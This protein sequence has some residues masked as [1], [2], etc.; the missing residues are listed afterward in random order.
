MP[1]GTAIVLSSGGPNGLGVARALA[2]D[3]VAVA[4][5]AKSRDDPAL[6]SNSISWSAVATEFGQLRDSLSALPAGLPQPRVLIPTSD[7]WVSTVDS[8]RQELGQS[9]ALAISDAHV[10]STLI[11]KALETRALQNAGFALPVTIH[12]LSIGADQI[13]SALGLPLIVK[14]RHSG[15]VRVLRA[16]NVIVHSREALATL[17]D[18][19][20]SSIDGLIAQEVIPG[21]DRHQFV[22]NCCFDRNSRLVSAFTFRRIRLSPAHRGVTSFAVSEPNLEIIS[23]VEQF[24]GIFGYVGPAMLEFKLDPR[25]GAFKYLETN[26]RVGMCNWFDTSCGVNNAANG[27]RVA[28]GHPPLQSRQ[29]PRHVFINLFEDTF[30]RHKDGDAWVN[31]VC[32]IAA[33]AARRRVY[34]YWSWRDPRPGFSM[35][36]KQ[37]GGHLKHQIQK[38]FGRLSSASVNGQRSTS[39]ATSTD[40]L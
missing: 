24:G 20:G 27:F 5:I 19:V 22:C 26:P 21:P 38:I 25:D 31:I 4:V 10:V 9:F 11:D 37:W 15:F 23:L 3:N 30:A 2:A 12:D 35:I 32:S 7:Q 8:Q 13:I 40:R 34:P 33:L 28:A 29:R 16:K 14:P 17:L 36:A 6:C 18:D 1:Q 39:A